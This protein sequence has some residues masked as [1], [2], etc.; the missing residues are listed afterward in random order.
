MMLKTLDLFIYV[1]ERTAV[2]V[3]A[4][5]PYIQRGACQKK[6][7]GEFKNSVPG[8]REDP[9]EKEYRAA[10]DRRASVDEYNERCFPHVAM[11]A[12]VSLLRST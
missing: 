11:T 10:S 7:E 9:S 12:I 3:F 4:F 6:G 8:K 5:E 2:R 1:I